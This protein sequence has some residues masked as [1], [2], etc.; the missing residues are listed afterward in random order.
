MPL[1]LPNAA[2]G[3]A[4]AVG[5]GALACAAIAAIWLI[6]S[7]LPAALPPLTLSSP[8]SA[9]QPAADLAA[10]AQASALARPLFALT[11][12]PAAAADPTAAAP[13]FDRISGIIITTHAATAMMQPKDGGKSVLLHVGDRFQGRL[14]SA[15]D[16]GGITLADGGR[17]RPGF[18]AAAAQ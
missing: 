1:V 3:S 14:I 17:L 8:A 11:R 4:W 10:A 9:A 12:R 16:A 13:S 18:G 15:I 7:A 2:S 6:P 5:G